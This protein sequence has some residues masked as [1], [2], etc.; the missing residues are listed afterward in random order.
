MGTSCR[1]LMVYKPSRK[2]TVACVGSET[3]FEVFKIPCPLHGPI[4]YYRW[5][6]R[7]EFGYMY[8]RQRSSRSDPLRFSCFES[9]R[10][11]A[12]P[13]GWNRSHSA[14][15][16]I[17]YR[18]GRQQISLLASWELHRGLSHAAGHVFT[19]PRE[20]YRIHKVVIIT[21][22]WSTGD[23]SHPG[24]SNPSLPMEILKRSRLLLTQ[25]KVDS[26]YTWTA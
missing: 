11:N 8:A 4:L 10:C 1:P 18:T 14:L 13:Y 21:A 22:R 6:C 26:G 5:L 17:V 16:R 9:R 20:A 19:L 12:Q 3:D 23:V 25:A 15:R 2:A 7:V 24:Q